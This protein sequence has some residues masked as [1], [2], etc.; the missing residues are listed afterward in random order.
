MN[1]AR[2]T[3]ATALALL[4]AGCAALPGSAPPPAAPALP[5][6]AAKAP[7]A[8]AVAAPKPSAPLTPEG[9]AARIAELEAARKKGKDADPDG[10]LALELALLYIHPDNPAPDHVKALAA[11][12]AYLALSAPASRDPLI[13][14]IAGLL[15]DI[16]KLGRITRDGRA[17][18][19]E[20]AAT[21]QGLEQRVAAA[22][23]RDAAAKKREQELLAQIKTLQQQ[24]EQLQRLDLEMEKRRRSVK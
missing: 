16:D 17:R 13:P 10:K 2:R 12:R 9:I 6:P 1:A 4:L 8:P 15:E 21:V 18:E 11:M 7:P 14:H 5:A 23:Q 3:L 20:L 24:I 22:D 19:K